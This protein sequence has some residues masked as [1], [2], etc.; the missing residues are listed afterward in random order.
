MGYLDK[1]NIGD[2]VPYGEFV[3]T[4]VAKWETQAESPIKKSPMGFEVEFVSAVRDG[5]EEIT[6]VR[7]CYPELTATDRRAASDADVAALVADLNKGKPAM[8]GEVLKPAARDAN[9]KPVVIQ[10]G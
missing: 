3:G 1:V 10:A 6:R 4:V 7:M 8:A 2:K 9:G 5:V